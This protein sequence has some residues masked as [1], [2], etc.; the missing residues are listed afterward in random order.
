M[1]IKKIVKKVAAKGADAVSRLSALSPEQLEHLET[2]R[3]EYLTALPD[4]NSPEALNQ[5]ERLLASSA[6]EI[7]N[8][9]LPQI[10]DLYVPLEQEVEYDGEFR[11][12]NNIRYINI[13]KWVTD[14]RENGLEKLVNVY[15]VLSND[16]CNISLVF[17][18]QKAQTAVYLAITN[19]N[20]A[21][22][23][24]DVDSY[25]RRL[26]SA[27][28]GNFP[29]STWSE[30]IGRG[31]LPCFK[32]N[33]PYSVATASN[34][35]TEKSEKFISQTIEKL[36]D[37]IVPETVQ[38][39]YILV[40]LATPI[41]D[42]AERKLTLS[43]IYSDLAPFASWQTNYTF[44]E[45]DARGS[46][47]TVGVN[48][49]ASA[50]SQ[51]GTTQS[52]TDTSGQT[53]TE[54]FTDTENQSVTE[55]ETITEGTSDTTTTTKGSAISNTTGVSATSASG[56]NANIGVPGGPSAGVSQTVSTGISNST[57]V[58][59]NTSIAKALT[60]TF[61]KA[62][63]NSLTKGTSLAKST[64]QAVSTSTALAKG[65]SQALNFGVNFGANFA[66]TS[67]VTATIGK[68]EGI[69]QTFTNHQ[70]KHALEL[71]D[72]QM[73][74]LEKSTALGMWDF[75]AYVLS[76]DPT[77]ANNV[78]HSYLALT[79]GED[80]HLSQTVVNLWRGDIV[81]ER[82]RA[83][84]LVAY[85]K[86]LR[87][88]IFGLNP[89]LLA[90]ADDLAVYPPLVTATT[91]LSG[92]ELAYALN[93]PQKSI[94]GLPVFEC[95]EFGRNVSSYS[96]QVGS[97]IRLGQIFHMN[98]VEPL[99]VDLQCQSLASHTFITGSTGTGKSNTIYNLLTASK[100]QGI[101]FLVI[102][103]AKGEYKH[104]FGHQDDV[105]VYGTNPR[106]SQLL[107]LNPFA[108]P[109]SI[110][111]L[112]HL[113]RLVELFNVC[114]P[115]YAAMPAILKK[116]LEEAYED[117]G[118]E[119][120][121]S[122][123]AHGK[124][125]P[126]FRDVSRRIKMIIDSSEYD[127]DNKGAYKGAL[128]TRLDTLTT[129]LNGQLFTSQAIPDQDLFDSNV[130]VDLSRVGSTETKALIMGLLVLKL[131]EYRLA[132]AQGLNQ[133]LKHL[134]VLEEAHHILKRTSTEQSS[135]SSNIL[136]KSVELLANSI[137]EM[138]TYGEGFIIADQAPALL[139][140]SV[141]RNT[142]TKIIL[143]LPDWEDREL[144][145]RSANLT[146]DQ[147]TELAKLPQGV[148]AVYQ[149]DWTE[150]VLCRVEK[151]A[152]EEK[153]YEYSEG[154]EETSED[155]YR[156]LLSIY[157]SESYVKRQ[158]VKEE[159][160]AKWCSHLNLDG[161]SQRL[162]KEWRTNPQEEP[163][164]HAH[165]PIIAQLY[166]SLVQKVRQQLDKKQSLKAIT[167][168][169]QKEL[170]GLVQP[171]VSEQVRRD[172]VQSVM[173]YYYLYEQVDQAGLQEWIRYGGF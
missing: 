69:T 20:N 75:A 83:S 3:Q 80:S 16:A 2:K 137:A 68:N 147:I 111:V 48:V 140:K 24:V 74:R 169:L 144:V 52:V 87:H 145:G 33:L 79:Q 63:N 150:A 100:E 170:G 55:G 102:E 35:P 91:A 41:R 27:I 39:E 131:Q 107:R 31:Q 120:L 128:L 11:S 1:G 124:I 51:T 46:S 57:T 88:P 84:E 97:S 26:T 23:N 146:D 93:F 165:A 36:L 89:N 18:R 47:A 125:Y 172:I 59:L 12:R 148:A 64:S 37:G 4:P 108:F 21:D 162:L 115:M 95:A 161:Q 101:K 61:S 67:T 90:T 173:V 32:T 77:V 163:N 143:R 17:H 28:K 8:A 127:A 50:G 141:I 19:T 164:F 105:T 153:Q 54:G 94:A 66:R 134:T 38:E 151:V 138:R 112:E 44:T 82:G 56:V 40:L 117:C 118:W 86:N 96:Q 65:A 9:Y 5:T 106:I 109:E 29:G 152:G 78:A 49:G 122:V 25:R 167:D 34:I 14:K 92:K 53:E 72:E 168:T 133:P 136:G 130:I 98:H 155:L 149:N 42:I 113:D 15:E 7:Y 157:L 171:E 110:H 156:S 22:N 70:V 73:K 85:L 114:W 139:D 103:P 129:G 158:L 135:E 58:G 6:V 142:N 76:E 166:P 45:S 132:T 159:Q 160:L 60:K 119:L 116:A 10:A 71:L 30:S 43:R 104:V 62:I 154:L 81:E 123:N 99:A 13:T 126:T 121:Q